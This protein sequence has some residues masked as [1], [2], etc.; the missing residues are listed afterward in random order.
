MPFRAVDNLDNDV[1]ACIIIKTNG[2]RKTLRLYTYIEDCQLSIVNKLKKWELLTE[3]KI[4]E[5]I[6]NKLENKYDVGF[7]FEYK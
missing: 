5:R 7:E 2:K 1:K 3:D 4:R 6:T